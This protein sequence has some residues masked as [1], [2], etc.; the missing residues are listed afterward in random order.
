MIGPESD[1][2][3]IPLKKT[4]ITWIIT[5]LTF[6]DYNSANSFYAFF[7]CNSIWLKTN[8]DL[9]IKHN[10]TTKESYFLYKEF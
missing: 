2:L 4:S 3:L 1:V 10:V 5:H 9:G 8:A 6:L 7:L